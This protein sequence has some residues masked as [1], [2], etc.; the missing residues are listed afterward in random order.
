MNTY[1]LVL[2]QLYQFVYNRKIE[3]VIRP[4]WMN[5]FGIPP[6]YENKS[7][8]ESTL[9]ATL[10]PINL[11]NNSVLFNVHPKGN[12]VQINKEVRNRTYLGGVGL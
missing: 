9:L 2:N 8:I 10:L 1:T 6:S 5:D 12:T 11:G 3:E 4:N 7:H